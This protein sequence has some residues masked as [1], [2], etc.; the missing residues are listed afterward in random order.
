MHLHCFR[1]KYPVAILAATEVASTL[2]E[3]A[4]ASQW[5]VWLNDWNAQF[6]PVAE[7]K[8]RDISQRRTTHKAQF[9]RVLTE[10]F[11]FLSCF[12]VANTAGRVSHRW[13][14][15]AWSSEVWISLGNRDFASVQ[16]PITTRGDYFFVYFR[17][18][19]SCHQLVDAGQVKS[20]C[21]RTKRVL[22]GRCFQL[23]EC[24]LFRLRE[25]QQL[26]GVSEDYLRQ[27]HVP[28][29][30]YDGG[31]WVYAHE[32]DQ[33]LTDYRSARRADLL[34]VLPSLTTYKSED[35]STLSRWNFS[36]GRY[37]GPVVTRGIKGE[38]GLTK[39]LRIVYCETGN[40]EASLLV[41]RKRRANI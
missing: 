38:K 12:D 3:P 7:E 19:L 16:R 41:R 4:L 39:L 11:K 37:L 17:A 34:A 35:V 29:R 28:I 40:P 9:C 21:P 5:E 15:T 27:A 26:M 36:K 13:S 30:E 6:K 2:Q 14:D 10:A 22:C 8:I 31:Q 20:V 24:T 1:P 32:A 18:C 25:Y 33:L 23:P